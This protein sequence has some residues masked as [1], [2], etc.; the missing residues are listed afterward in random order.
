MTKTAAIAIARRHCAIWGRGTSWTVSGPYYHHRP[1]GPSTEHQCSSYA[2]AVAIRTVWR[3]RIA[4]ALMLE[5]NA[6]V[7]NADVDYAA[8]WAID[9]A[10]HDTHGPRTL[11][12]LVKIGLAAARS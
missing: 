2:R 3:A 5:P 7:A 9:E 4:L 6:D 10:I 12:A 8:R 1:T 11:P